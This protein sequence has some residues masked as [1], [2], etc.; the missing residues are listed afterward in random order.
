[1]TSFSSPRPGPTSRYVASAALAILVATF[2]FSAH[3]PALAASDPGVIHHRE[4]LAGWQEKQ[5]GGTCPSQGFLRGPGVGG[6]KLVLNVS[7]IGKNDED[8]GLYGYWALDH[9]T[10]NLKV[11]SL[12]NG[13]YYAEKAY[14]GV[15]ITPQ[16]AVSPGSTSGPPTGLVENVTSYGKISGG[17]VGTF[18]GTFEPGT[19]RTYGFIGTFDYG[20]T[21]HD[22]L[23]QSYGNGQ[24][25]D[26]HAYDWESAYFTGG[27]QLNEGHWGWSY[28]LDPIFQGSSSV[29]QWCNY[30]TA[31]GG[32]S[33]DI[34]SP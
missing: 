18:S 9:F 30:N 8:S 3:L 29:N 12:P 1:M 21:L 11:W 28:E 33:G 2:G 5:G 24:V 13:T 17:Y 27:S 4:G 25:G 7:W 14:D 19:Q 22:V 26:R 10:E 20:G 16:G 15:F 32:N 6:Q 31:D 34:F 23:L